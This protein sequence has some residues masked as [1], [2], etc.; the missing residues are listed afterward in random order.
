MRV[1]TKSAGKINRWGEEG[2]EVVERLLVGTKWPEISLPLESNCFLF[3]CLAPRSPLPVRRE[4]HFSAA[5]TAHREGRKNNKRATHDR[6]A[7]SGNV[8]SNIGSVCSRMAVY[9]GRRLFSAKT[10]HE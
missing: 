8:S 7:I 10:R 1:K 4:G 9:L 6:R 3:L 5:E 2:R